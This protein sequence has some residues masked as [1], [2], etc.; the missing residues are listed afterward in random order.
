[1]SFLINPQNKI[2]RFNFLILLVHFSGMAFSQSDTTDDNSEVKMIMSLEKQ[3]EFVGGIQA[4][5]KYIYSNT[6]YTKKARKDSACGTVYVGFW[7]TK[8]GEIKDPEILKGIHPDLDSIAIELIKQMP[9]W[10]PGKQRGRPVDAQ[11]N[12][13]IRF[14]LNK[15]DFQDIPTETSRYW[16]KRGKRKFIKTCLEDY[17]KTEQECECWYSFIIWNYNYLRLK[18]ID[19]DS[20]FNNQYCK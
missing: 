4:L 9:D 14:Q 10:I 6:D 13:P 1:M 5:N 12:L 18:D 7:V 19:L 11:Y 16:R 2:L 17:G 8:T 3:P 20:M 15:T